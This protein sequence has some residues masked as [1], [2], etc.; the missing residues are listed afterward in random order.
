MKRM[1]GSQLHEVVWSAPPCGSATVLEKLANRPE[2]WAL[3][4]PCPNESRA[5]MPQGFVQ[6]LRGAASTLP[7]A[8]PWGA[9]PSLT[10]GWVTAAM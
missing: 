6:P 1:G 10:D 2:I 9:P 8:A 4:P 5:N 3:P 7:L